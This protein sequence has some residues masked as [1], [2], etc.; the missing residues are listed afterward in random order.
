LASPGRI[1]VIWEKRLVS[2]NPDSFGSWATLLPECID[3]WI[4]ESNPVRVI[5]FYT[6]KTLSRLSTTGLPM[7]HSPSEA[8]NIDTLHARDGRR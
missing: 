8:R 3:E 2:G 6:T 7:P 4:D 5:G 1:R